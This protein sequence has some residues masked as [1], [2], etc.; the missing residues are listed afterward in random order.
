MKRIIFTDLDGTLLDSNTYSYEKAKDALN[1]L[2]K[3]KIPLIFCTSKT[4]AEIEYWRNK[5]N[6]T[7]PFISENGGG[8]FIPK[9]FF[10][11]SFSYDKEYPDYFVIE[12][13]KQ[14]NDLIQVFNNL[15]EKY[16]I[17]SFSD[18]ST[19]EIA[20]D[21]NLELFQAQLAKKREFDLPFKI[22]NKNQ[23]QDILNEIKKHGLNY[24][25][26]GRYYHLVGNNNKGEAVKIL[27]NI[28]Q[29]KYDVI[30]TI[31]IGDS[32]ND[33]QML[34]V[35][36]EGYLV[37]KKNG[38]YESNKYKK[39]IGIGPKGWNKIIKQKVLS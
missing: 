7:D 33:F 34:D 36:D 12:L 17:I 14:Y 6:N 8:I 15:K 24:T 31:A 29:K 21:A 38:S 10:S 28:F 26:G 2:K 39:G 22:L 11:F 25:V 35:V 4:R 32:K 19:L 23:E 37:Q 16:N 20:R 9:N 13:G 18:M 3:L 30:K 1:L 5:I 27:S